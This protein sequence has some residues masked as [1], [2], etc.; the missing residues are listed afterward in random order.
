[1]DVAMTVYE[2]WRY[3]A[4]LLIHAFERIM[5]IIGVFEDEDHEIL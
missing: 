5:I 3:I 1:M 2:T 4:N